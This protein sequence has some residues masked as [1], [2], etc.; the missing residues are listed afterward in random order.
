MILLESTLDWSPVLTSTDRD[1]TDDFDYHLV[2]IEGLVEVIELL[3]V[4]I[5]VEYNW[6]EQIH[7]NFVNKLLALQ[8]NLYYNYATSYFIQYCNLERRKLYS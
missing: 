7:V 8:L 5:N 1:S 3:Y 4:R 2:K 6:F